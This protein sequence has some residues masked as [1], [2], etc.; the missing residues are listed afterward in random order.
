MDTSASGP[1]SPCLSASFSSCAGDSNDRNQNNTMFW[2]EEIGG[3]HNTREDQEL[4]LG[5]CESIYTSRGIYNLG[6]ELPYSR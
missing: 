5:N 1:P 6:P 3:D 4:E 2:G